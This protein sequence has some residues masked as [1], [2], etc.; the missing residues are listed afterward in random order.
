MNQS[1]R[2]AV[3]EREPTVHAS[4]A[5]RVLVLRS[6]RPAEFADAVRLVKE[7]HPGAEVVA[8]SHAGHE[9]SLREAGVDAVIELPGTR[10]GLHRIAPWRLMKLRGERFDEIVIPQMWAS[11]EHHV[12]LYWLVA[13][14]RF[15]RVAIVAKGEPPRFIER[16][17]FVT[18]LPLLS[19][20]RVVDALDVPMLLGLL[21]V[22]R[23]VR[24]RRVAEP[25][26]RRRV[27]HVIPSLGMGG[28]QRQLFE[29]VNATPA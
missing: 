5:R 6:C 3:L 19:F 17:A 15:D 10:F 7:R 4:T 24:R 14:L 29:V 13:S 21:L 16:T 2:D 20:K 8:L 28:A 12:N 26:R 25:G 22:S 11:P 1:I 18:S 9:G 27:L 23:V